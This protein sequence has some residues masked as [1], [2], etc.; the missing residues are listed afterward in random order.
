MFG[1]IGNP[2]IRAIAI[3]VGKAAAKKLVEVVGRRL[4]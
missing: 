3:E 1:F 4:D 2:I